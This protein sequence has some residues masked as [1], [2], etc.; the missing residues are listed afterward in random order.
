MYMYAICCTIC[1]FN[2]ALYICFNAPIDVRERSWKLVNIGKTCKVRKK[3]WEVE[4][5]EFVCKCW[6]I[7]GYQRKR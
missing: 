3:G 2:L 1:K 6:S 4:S 5:I 7:L